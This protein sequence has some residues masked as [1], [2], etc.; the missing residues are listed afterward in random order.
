MEHTKVGRRVEHPG[1]EH[2]GEFLALWAY[3]SLKD[4][5]TMKQSTRLALAQSDIA[6]AEKRLKALQLLLQEEAYSDV[7]REA[8]ELVEL[9]LKGIL[10]QAG[11]DPPKQHDIGRYLRQIQDRLPQPAAG[12]ADR[13]GAISERLGKERNISFYGD[14]DCIPAENYT[15]P[16]AEQALADAEYVYRLACD[17][18]R[19]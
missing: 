1:V 18:I 15:R 17:V 6:K 11:I 9:A 12:R 10:F 16:E 3:F 8:Q 2:S 7:M 5:H 14:Q 4:G 19:P 13:L